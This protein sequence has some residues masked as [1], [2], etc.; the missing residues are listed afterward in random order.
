MNA[1]AQTSDLIPI[2]HKH[3]GYFSIDNIRVSEH[4]YYKEV[5]MDVHV[6]VKDLALEDGIAAPWYSIILTNENG[7]TYQPKVTTGKD[8]KVDPYTFYNTGISGADGGIGM[9]CI[10][11]MVE[12]E[13]N[14]FNVYYQIYS[15]PDA[16]TYH[17]YLIG[18]IDL[19]QNPFSNPI[20]DI[21]NIN[22]T[23]PV[24]FFSQLIEWFKNLFHFS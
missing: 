18:N 2:D 9:H 8:C 12:K 1:A 23:K 20:S 21:K 19:T 14:K 3:Y 11:F 13:F 17:N 7:K 4:E 22:M 15:T 16:T 5:L 24:D 10:S 6:K